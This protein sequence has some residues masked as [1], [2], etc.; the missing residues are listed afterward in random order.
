MSYETV[1]DYDQRF[2]KEDGEEER[3]GEEGE[4]EGGGRQEEDSAE[5][6]HKTSHRGSGKTLCS[7]EFDLKRSQIQN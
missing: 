7:N 5:V 1:T 6:N 2:S 3:Q 4:E